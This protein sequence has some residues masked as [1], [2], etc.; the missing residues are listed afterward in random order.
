MK[1]LAL[2][3]AAAAMISTPAFAAPSDSE[4]FDI[5]ASIPETCTMEGINDINLGEI[6]INTAAGS[7]ALLINSLL[8][9][10]KAGNFWLS[11]N[12]N[13]RMTFTQANGVLKNQTRS[14][15]SGDDAGFKDT[16]NYVVNAVNY[17]SGFFALQP[18]CISGVG[19]ASA[20]RGA[21]HRKIDMRASVS[22]IGQ[23]GLRPLA[24]EYQD[25]VTVTVTTI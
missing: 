2:V 18:G 6:S 14:V 1:K 24:G 12:E 20:N 3:A 8:D 17:K 5:N 23:N 22:A 7:N 9:T 25:T 19:C 11:C 4:S 15:G 21:I 10:G 16:I 13:N